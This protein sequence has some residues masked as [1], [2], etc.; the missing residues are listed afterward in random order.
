MKLAGRRIIVGITGSI[1]AYKVCEVVRGLQ[2]EGAELRIVMTDSA[3]QLVRPIMFRSLT[4]APVYTTLWSEVSGGDLTHVTLTDWGELV[5]V[6]PATANI[7]G[8][9]ASGIAD[10]LLSTTIMAANCPTI[11]VPAMNARMWANA[12]VQRNVEYLRTLGYRFCGPVEGR[13]AS[14]ALGIGRMA[15]PDSVIQFVVQM[16]SRSDSGKGLKVVVTAG[17]TRE[18]IDP[19]RFISNP[20]S[21]KMGYAIAEAARDSGAEVILISGPTALQHLSGVRTIEVETHALMR[22]AV[23]QYSR[24]ADV[25]IS[26]AAVADFT[27]V[28]VADQKLRRTGQ[29]LLLRLRPTSD[30]IAEVGEQKGNRILI[31]FAAETTEGTETAIRK[32]QEKN[33]DLIVLNNVMEPESGFEVDTNRATLI[34]RDRPPE[35]LPLLTKRELAQRVWGE[36]LQLVNQRPEHNKRVE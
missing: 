26:A 1:A 22:E 17:P 34:W 21:G 7:I 33:L 8:K 4:G 3:Q 36:A 25:V 24:Q 31:G 27:P 28:E 32:L 18:F 9:V 5:V 20:S 16:L 35:E 2:D 15:A 14:G 11:F 12:V 13:L 10:D 6:V 19:I 30:I 23:L 29:E